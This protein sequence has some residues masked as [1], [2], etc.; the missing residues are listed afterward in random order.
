M[1]ECATVNAQ[2]VATFQRGELA[3]E[4]DPSVRVIRRR[5]P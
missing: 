3:D 1:S 4:R 5:L 2:Q